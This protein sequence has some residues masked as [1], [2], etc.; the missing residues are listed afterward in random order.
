MPK[1]MLFAL[2]T[3]GWCRKAK[4]FFDEHEVQYDYVYVDQLQGE[5]RE[6]VMAEVKRWNPALSFPTIVFD[7]RTVVVG[8]QEDRLHELLKV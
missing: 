2:S 1:V 5:K 3:C 4:A 8:F 7:G 6:Q